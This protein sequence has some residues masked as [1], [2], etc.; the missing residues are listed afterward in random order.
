MCVS[1]PICV[2]VHVCVFLCLY[3]CY[4]I[5]LD[6]MAKGVCLSY[7]KVSSA[8]KNY[9][10]VYIRTCSLWFGSVIVCV[11]LLTDAKVCIVWIFTHEYVIC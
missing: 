10:D 4:C 7:K 6:I 9:A 11:F 2:C 1:V 3:L 8:R 5:D